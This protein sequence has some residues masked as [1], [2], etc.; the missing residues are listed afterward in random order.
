MIRKGHLGFVFGPREVAVCRR[1]VSSKVCFPL[2]LLFDRLSCNIMQHDIVFLL[3]ASS[4]RESH[5]PNVLFKFDC[6]RQS[7]PGKL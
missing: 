5:S 7:A 2:A 1:S 4:K 3:A 6:H